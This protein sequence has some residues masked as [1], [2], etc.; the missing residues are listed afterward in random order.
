M[1][2]NV[3]YGTQKTQNTLSKN[4]KNKEAPQNTKSGGGQNYVKSFPEKVEMT[5]STNVFEELHIQ[6]V[7]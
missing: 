5:K 4:S 1:F 7:E 2:L 6:K 3:F